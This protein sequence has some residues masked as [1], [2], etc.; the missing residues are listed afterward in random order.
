MKAIGKNGIA[1]WSEEG[2]IIFDRDGAPA[3]VEADGTA[4]WYVMGESHRESGAAWVDARGNKDFRRLGDLP[5][6]PEWAG[7]FAFRTKSGA[8][9][10]LN[11]PRKTWRWD[12]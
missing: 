9:I 12:G 7:K 8:V 2:D 10:P 11:L 1:W 5:E 3:L 4:C 6:F